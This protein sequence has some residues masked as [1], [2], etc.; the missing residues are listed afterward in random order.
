MTTQQTNAPPVGKNSLPLQIRPVISVDDI[1]FETILDR[2]EQA[3]LTC[4]ST[5]KAGVSL[6]ARIVYLEDTRGSSKIVLPVITS[7]GLLFREGRSYVSN[8]RLD[9]VVVDSLLTQL[10]L[11]LVATAESKKMTK[12]IIGD[13]SFVPGHDTALPADFVIYIPN[14]D[15]HVKLL[16]CEEQSSSLSSLI[17]YSYHK[18]GLV[19]WHVDVSNGSDRCVSVSL[20]EPTLSAQYCRM[21]AG[22]THGLTLLIRDFIRN[23]LAIASALN[24]KSGNTSGTRLYFPGVFDLAADVKQHYNDKVGRF[25]SQDQSEAGGIR[26]FNNL[27]K[28]VLLNHFV[29]A[30]SGSAQ[31]GPV[32]LDLACGHGQD[33]MKFRNKHPKLY[34]G[35]DISQEALT[36]ARRRHKGGNIRYPADFMQGNLMLP[37]TYTEIRRKVQ[38][39]GIME[40]APFDVISMQLALHY[41]VGSEAEAR[42]FFDNIFKLLKP[43]GRFIA[44]FPCSNRIAHRMRNLKY[45]EEET[46][47]EWYFGNETYRV[48]FN[49]EE[50]IRI[51]PKLEPAFSA[52]SEEVL[53]K[54]L[55]EIDFEQV[56]NTVGETW[57]LQYKFY[58]IQTIDNQEEY[59]VPTCAM[60]RMFNE[61]KLDT[62]MTANFAE[63]IAHYTQQ[64]SPVIRDFRKHN[65]TLELNPDEDEVFRFYR[66]IVVRK[67]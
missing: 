51:I 66:A 49:T 37:E 47:S 31:R 26:K 63:I 55:E 33:L 23:S 10:E 64:E 52:K 62:E 36:E 41:L 2:V 38:A 5:S 14:S 58:L 43:G 13:D 65:A 15:F 34:I 16:I 57:G 7:P 11:F 21:Q 56:A 39:F 30:G 3:L 27:I 6:I 54:E 40:D 8:P 32:I 4:L 28:S 22:Q 17:R 18:E 46:G 12:R 44:T 67:D 59:V 61:M 53:D 9:P 25:V 45:A 60:E 42:L 35:L 29:P 20:S 1:K 48:T 24:E 19:L 50:A